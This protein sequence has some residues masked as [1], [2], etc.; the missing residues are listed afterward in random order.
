MTI[1]ELRDLDEA[2][3]FVTQGLWLQRLVA[4]VK[5][6]VAQALEWALAA[7]AGEQCLPAVGFVSDLGH[8]LLSVAVGQK[9]AAPL[10]V[11]GFPPGLARAYED[12]VL[13]KIAAD[14][15]LERAADALRRY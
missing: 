14:F 9:L 1:I 15:S 11:P 12:Y 7:A 3:A 2:R 10:A 8:A 5:E 4:P 13:G 6:N